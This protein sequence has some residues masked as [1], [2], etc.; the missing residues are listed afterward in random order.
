MA[1]ITPTQGSVLGGDNSVQIW[2]WAIMANGDA[3]SP[4]N[5]TQWADRSVQVTGTFGA[6]GNLRWEGS[7]DG[8]NYAPL[9]DPQGNALDFTAAKIEQVEEITFWARPRVTAGDGTTSVT[10][11]LCARRQQPLRV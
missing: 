9:T 7:N 4:I 10:V 1:T 3:G 6:S 11:T 5:F 8:T 2:T